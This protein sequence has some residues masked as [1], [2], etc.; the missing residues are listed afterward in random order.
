MITTGIS[1]KKSDKQ[2]IN[3]NNQR[4]KVNKQKV[5]YYACEIRIA[6]DRASNFQD[7]EIEEIDNSKF[8]Y[9][10]SLEDESSN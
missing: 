2:I 5:E 3:F 8:G 4:I 6:D 10:S 1:T 7:L 9:Q